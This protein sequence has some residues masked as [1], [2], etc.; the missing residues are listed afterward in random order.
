MYSVILSLAL[1]GSSESPGVFLR[2]R[3]YTPAIPVAAYPWWGPIYPYAP[4]YGY[5]PW[6]YPFAYAPYFG[7]YPWSC[8]AYYNPW[9]AYY[10]WYYYPP[11][12]YTAPAGPRPP[13]TGAPK[14]MPEPAPKKGG[15]TLP[16]PAV[17]KKEE[18]SLINIKIPAG[19]TLLVDGQP[20]PSTGAEKGGVKTFRT[21]ALPPGSVQSYTF[22]IVANEK[23]EPVSRAQVVQFRVGDTITVDLTAPPTGVAANPR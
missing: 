4:W 1:A 14:K 12:Y 18:V 2:C 13:A 17:P 7:Y 3:F 21:P 16:P 15:E 8:G 10:P 9:Y 20:A 11:V 5:Y 19:A 22:A 23:G 6:F